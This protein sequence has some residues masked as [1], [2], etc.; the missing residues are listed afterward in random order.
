[1][2][3]AATE[4]KFKKLWIQSVVLAITKILAKTHLV[5]FKI[6][7]KAKKNPQFKILVNMATII[8]CNNIKNEIPELIYNIY[9]LNLKF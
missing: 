9:R 1:M 8:H 5:L 6:M 2:N 4:A 7:I 3:Q